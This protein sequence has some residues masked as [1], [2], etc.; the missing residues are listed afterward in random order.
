MAG[1]A[2]GTHASRVWTNY[3]YS[4]QSNRG[5][6]EL[7]NTDG[8]K[9]KGK[10]EAEQEAYNYAFAW[11][12]GISESFTFLIPNFYGSGSGAGQ[13]IGKDSKTAKVFES[14]GIPAEQAQGM[15]YYWGA[16][17]FTSGPAYLGVIVCLLALFGVMAST[18]PLRWWLLGS[19]I[20]LIMIAWGKNFAVF[21]DL[22]YY[23]MPLFS[24]FR[25]HTM[26][27]SLLQLFVAGLALLGLHAFLTEGADTKKLLPKL[28]ISGGMIGGLCLVFALLGSSLQDFSATGTTE[29]ATEDGKS[30]Q[31]NN[32]QAFLNQLAR[33]FKEDTDTPK[34][35]LRA[36]REDRATMQSNDAWRSFGFVAVTVLALWAVSTFFLHWSYGLGAIALLALL[37]L[38]SVD[39]RYLNNTNFVSKSDY[40]STFSLSESENK[41]LEDNTRYR[42]ANFNRG[43]ASDAIT[44]YNFPSI[45]GYHGTKL[46]RYQEVIEKHF[47]QNTPAVYDML[48]LKYVITQNEAGEARATKSPSAC[49]NAWFVGDYDI[50]PDADAEIKALSSLKPLEKAII[51]KR[52]EKQ[53]GKVG[54]AQETVGKI[55]LTKALPDELTYS[56]DNAKEQIA[57]FSEIYYVQEGKIF[58]QAYIDD[59]PVPHFRANYIL[60]G[61]VVPAGKHT[62]KFK[63]E[64]PI[65]NTGEMIALICSLLLFGLL[66]ASA[67]FYYRQ[68]S[69]KEVPAK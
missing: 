18:N 3:E 32:D 11:S 7:K 34:R 51:D 55:K 43:I 62:I 4:S 14:L 65:Y 64:A 42:V 2:L 56:T 57:I 49:G 8:K 67:Y 15:P 28:Y 12:Y 45:G 58:W 27:L 17:P 63:F 20:F 54:K 13:E 26:T 60:R 22:L 25:A 68:E 47:A 31:V 24:K 16:Q 10:T 9:T 37:D 46:M 40:E 41:I 48:N 69:A 44:S 23:Y 29:M 38:W 39:R 35:I 50:V 61:L 19:S 30:K 59:K 21:N 1:I 5:K 36:I 66:G 53:V 52:F 33:S 6:S